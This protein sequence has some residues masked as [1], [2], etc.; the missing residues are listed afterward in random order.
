MVFSISFDRKTKLL[1]R[2]VLVALKH[3][4]ISIVKVCYIS[5]NTNCQNYDFQK[6]VLSEFFSIFIIT[7]QTIITDFFYKS[8]YSKTGMR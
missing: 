3:V 1:V 4:D 5:G 6:N 2:G 8:H 7:T